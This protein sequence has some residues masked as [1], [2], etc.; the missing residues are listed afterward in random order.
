MRTTRETLLKLAKDYTEQKLVSD[1]NVTAVFLVGSVRAETAPLPAVLD[2]DLLVIYNGEPPRER[3]IIKLS[4]EVHLDIA[5]EPA[6][7]Y[8]QPRELRGDPWRGWAMWDPQLLHEKGRFFEYTQAIVRSHFDETENLLNRCRKFSVPARMG[9]N[10]MFFNPETATPLK[11]LSAAQNAANAFA[12]LAGPPLT[13]RTL[14]SGFAARAETLQMPEMTGKLLNILS[15]DLKPDL[16]KQALPHWEQAFLSAAP[17]S[18]DA[19]LHPVRLKYYKTSIESQ[20]AGPLPAAAFW[21]LLHT[22]ALALSL[23][24][25]PPENQAD[26]DDFCHAIGL[27]P[28]RIAERI[29]ALDAFLDT[30]EET[31]EQK[32]G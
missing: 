28:N 9:W 16:V 4:N 29:D 12:T 27:A 32:A 18:P 2:V 26:W 20:L 3:E 14:L 10:E 24:M 6:R 17:G 31:L 23:P 21:P 13:E 22:W 8:A 11:I 1:R 7:L 25:T 15:G 5:F 30:L 19:R